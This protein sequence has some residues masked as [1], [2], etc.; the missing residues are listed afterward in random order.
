MYYAYWEQKEVW[1][2]NLIM[3]IIMVIVYYF[4]QSCGEAMRAWWAGMSTTMQVVFVAAQLA[5]MG[6]FGED[7][8]VLGQLVS[9]YLG[10]AGSS[11]ATVGANL[12]TANAAITVID[13]MNTSEML[14]IM[15]DA[16][17][18]ASLEISQELLKDAIQ[19]GLDEEYK[20][21]GYYYSAINRG[22]IQQALVNIRKVDTLVAMPS[23]RYFQRVLK[24]TSPR[25]TYRLQYK[26][27]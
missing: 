1:N 24:T 10:F 26:Y 19:D 4:C 27:T 7:Y 12:A 14:H 18:I 3:I 9:L 23:E 22:Y 17:A 8:I 15:S 25:H 13:I 5:A 11:G 21:S 20:A 6:V 16:E 2:W